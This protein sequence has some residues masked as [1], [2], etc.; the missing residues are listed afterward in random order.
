MHILLVESDLRLADVYADFLGGLG[1]DVRVVSASSAALD[2]WQ[3]WPPDVVILD[4]AI[5]AGERSLLEHPVVH[6]S[7]IP[8]IAVFAGATERVG[9]ECLHLGAV[10]F[11]P[12]P[13]SFERLSAILSWLEIYAVEG[14]DRRPCRAPRR[15]SPCGCGPRRSGPRWT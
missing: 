10:D 14:G 5:S 15:T 12:K 9:R 8:V 4:M 13:M 2:Q 1:H 6:G 3:S 11:L 7:G